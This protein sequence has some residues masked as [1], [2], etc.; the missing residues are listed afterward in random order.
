MRRSAQQLLGFGI[1]LVAATTL[2]ACGDKDTPANSV[3]A[4]SASNASTTESTTT[5]TAVTTSKP[6]TQT[7]VPAT[8]PK[9]FLV[10]AKALHVDGKDRLQFTFNDGTPGYSAEYVKAPIT[11]EGEGKAIAISG[12]NVLKLV[13]ENAGTVDLTAGTKNYY[14]G[15]TRFSPTDTNTVSEVVKVSEYEGR[16]LFGIGTRA[17][18]PFS[19]TTSGNILTV[20]FG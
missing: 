9:R 14:T 17:A 12:D 3:N 1:A 6:G 2:G 7:S 19:T 16:L 11:D 15:Q 5:T 20:T 18:T 10:D 8:S 13:F 4:S